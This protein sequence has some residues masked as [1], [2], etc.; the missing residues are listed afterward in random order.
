M[1][2]RGGHESGWD[3][4]AEGGSPNIKAGKTWI[5]NSVKNGGP[6]TRSGP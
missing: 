2:G 6:T 5:G 3:K 1:R 4:T